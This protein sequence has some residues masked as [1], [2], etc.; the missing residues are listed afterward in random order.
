MKSILRWA[1]V[2]SRRGGSSSSVP[3]E[4][5]EEEVGVPRRP[6]SC[7]ANTLDGW[8]CWATAAESRDWDRDWDRELSGDVERD[9]EELKEDDRA[10]DPGMLT[11]AEP[12][13]ALWPGRKGKWESAVVSETVQ[14][15]SIYVLINCPH[16]APPRCCRAPLTLYPETPRWCRWSS[17]P[18]RILG[19]SRTR[20]ITWSPPPSPRRQRVDQTQTY[21]SQ[22]PPC[23]SPGRRE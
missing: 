9:E 20:Q 16:S 15:L 2:K 23:C 17:G 11:G 1:P 18:E 21:R 8:F 10:R 14:Y 3:S 19:E 5:W 12:P 4:F 13:S 7:L 6:S 22:T